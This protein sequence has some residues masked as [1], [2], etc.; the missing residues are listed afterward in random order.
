MPAWWAPTGLLQ[1]L[2]GMDTGYGR[3][4]ETDDK[5]VYN[6]VFSYMEE[7]VGRFV[8]AAGAKREIVGVIKDL[9]PRDRRQ[10]AVH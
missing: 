8:T 9:P 1:T 6:V 5:G 7:A 2:A 10:A 3:T 4:R